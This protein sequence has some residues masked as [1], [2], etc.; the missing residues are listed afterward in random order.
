MK[1][2]KDALDGTAQ[3]KHAFFLDD[4][5]HVGLNWTYKRSLTILS[6]DRS[7][8]EYSYMLGKNNMVHLQLNR[9]IK[10]LKPTG[11][12]QHLFDFGVWH[13]YRTHMLPPDDPRK[14]LSLNDLG[15]G[16]VIFLAAIFASFLVFLYEVILAVRIRRWLR[17]LI[18]LVDFLRV[19]NARLENYHDRW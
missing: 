6:G 4:I 17:K 9:L 3:H 1:H 2:Y 19:L 10:R 13:F 8:K 7:T 16:F 18:G 15:F 12:I 11:I 14:I 5:T